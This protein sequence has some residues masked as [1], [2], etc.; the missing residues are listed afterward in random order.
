MAH[1][2]EARRVKRELDKE[3]AATA[4][5]SG[6]TLVWSA[7]DRKLLALLASAIDR[8]CDL[9]DAYAVAVEP[10]LRIKL[11]AELRLLEA[12]IAR[13]LRAVKT[14]VPEPMSRRSQKAQMAAR[15]RW[16]RDA[17]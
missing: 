14:D 6:R 10:K 15:A 17:G 3:L 5:A 12:S 2:P 7:A 8:E 16:S 13:L 11:S 9:R 1:S 4:A